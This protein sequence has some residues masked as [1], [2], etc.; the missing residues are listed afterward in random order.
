MKKNICCVSGLLLSLLGCFLTIKSIFD[1]VKVLMSFSKHENFPNQYLDWFIF[2]F[3]LIFGLFA[4]VFV[5]VVCIIYLV[6][7]SNLLN[8]TRL[9][10][11]EYKEAREKKKAEKQA[12]KKQKL[13]EQ[14]KRLEE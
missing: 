9:T 10:Y 5:C 8:F 12:K 3:A 1:V 14:L 7:G 4:L 2:V 6:K 13:E 11:E